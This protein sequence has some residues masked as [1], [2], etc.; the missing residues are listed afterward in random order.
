MGTA[1]KKGR[2]G[3]DIAAKFLASH[4]YEIIERNYRCAYGEID[5]IARKE[6]I[7]VVA[8]VK[9]RREGSAFPGYA[10]VGYT[11]RDKLRKTAALWLSGQSEEHIIRFDVIEIYT[12]G[13]QTRINH[14]EN[15]FY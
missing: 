8:E 7:T 3:E 14:I 11:K 15:A 12:D 1:S 6:N 13:V 10:A 4:G 5:I 2:I 9:M